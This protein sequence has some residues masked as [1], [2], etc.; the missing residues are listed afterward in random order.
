MFGKALCLTL[1]FSIAFLSV[2]CTEAP[3]DINDSVTASNVNSK[4]DN[5]HDLIS[6]ACLEK[7]IEFLGTYNN[8]IACLDE[9]L[10]IHG[11]F[12]YLVS[13][14]GKNLDIKSEEI[15]NELGDKKFTLLVDGICVG[16]CSRLIMPLAS[17]V[18]FS[19]KSFAI[20]TDSSIETRIHNA[21]AFTKFSMMKNKRDLSGDDVQKILSEKED[22]QD[23]LRNQYFS[24]VR[25]LELSAKS[26]T[27]LTWHAHERLSLESRGKRECRPI[28]SLGVVLTPEYLRMNMFM[29]NGTYKLPSEDYI[30]QSLKPV[31]GDNPTLIYSFQSQ[32]FYGCGDWQ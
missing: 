22:Y 3:S 13:F 24:D 32:P 2:S 27:H 5:E 12:D 16:A 14:G 9:N 19:D 31:L 18:S 10:K 20:L 17:K 8:N 11:D 30:I 21:L 23:K 4:I 25:I 6:E 1:G 26:A 15:L 28:R 29:L 7:S